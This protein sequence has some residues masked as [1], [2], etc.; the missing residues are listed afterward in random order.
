MCV[1]RE[2]AAEKI[3]HKLTS[4]S[5]C[6]EAELASIKEVYEREISGLRKALDLA[7]GERSKLQV[8]NKKLAA[9]HAEM[10]GLLA[11]RNK[12]SI[13]L[14]KRIETLE[15]ELAAVRADAKHY[16]NIA[17]RSRQTS[18]AARNAKETTGERDTSS[19]RGGK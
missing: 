2:T 16:G 10:S 3:S 17:R 15:V 7:A 14:E 11:Q 9:E 5:E 12:D 19:N 6:H 18:E 8:D 4:F 1:V 13:S